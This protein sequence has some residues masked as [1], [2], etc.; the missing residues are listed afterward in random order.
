MILLRHTRP[1]DAEGL[2]YGRSD[3]DL[4]D[5]EFEAEA[6]RLV[7]DLP[8]V[9]NVVS[10]PLR[11]CLLL[12]KRVAAARALP[13]CVDAR[14]AEMDFGAWEG[15]RWDAIPRAELDVWAAD[16]HGAR[17]HGGES[18][19]ELGARVGMAL[20]EVVA[21]DPPTLWV[22]HAGVV[23]AACAAAGQA[24]GWETR[25]EFGRWL[26]LARRPDDRSRTSPWRCR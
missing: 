16:F 4:D 15:L 24:E 25:L 17:P 7:G 13:L 14:L 1:R 6:E 22:T 11:R 19:A 10:S 5:D 9:A 20:G 8:P 3:L 12:A 26:R 18:V 21:Q 23:R 2:C